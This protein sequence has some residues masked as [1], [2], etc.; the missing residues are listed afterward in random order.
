VKTKHLV[1]VIVVVVVLV[2]IEAA[3]VPVAVVIVTVVVVISLFIYLL[4]QHPR[5]KLEIKHEHR[6]NKISTYTQTENKTRRLFLLPICTL[7]C[8][9][10]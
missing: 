5:G 8:V 4:T 9:C 2:V 6:G 1:V 10:N 7:C 3:A